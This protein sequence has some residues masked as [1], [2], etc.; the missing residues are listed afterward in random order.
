MGRGN[1]HQPE[2]EVHLLQQ[3]EV[4]VANG[5]PTGQACKEAGIAEQIYYRWKPRF[6]D[7]EVDPMRHAFRLLLSTIQI[8]QI[9]QLRL[10]YFPDI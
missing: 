7:L 6:A 9:T 2:Q 3:I 5:K 4:A 10:R 8:T 1:R